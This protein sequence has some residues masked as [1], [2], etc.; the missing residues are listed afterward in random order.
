MSGGC[1]RNRKE[2]LMLYRMCML[3]MRPAGAMTPITASKVIVAHEV[4]VLCR[5]DGRDGSKGSKIANA[6]TR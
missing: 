3:V 2:A 1:G 6:I 5:A 4:K